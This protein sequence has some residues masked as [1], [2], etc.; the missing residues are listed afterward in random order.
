MRCLVLLFMGLL[1]WLA[2]GSFSYGQYSSDP[3]SSYIE[4]SSSDVYPIISTPDT[5]PYQSYSYTYSSEPISS[6]HVEQMIPYS[7]E[8][9]TQNALWVQDA[10]G[11]QTQYM[12]CSAFSQFKII[13]YSSGGS[14]IMTE[15]YPDGL[16]THNFYQF[17]PGYTEMVFAADQPGRHILSYELNGQISNAV[18]ID[19]VGQGQQEVYPSVVDMTQQSTPFQIDSIIRA[20]SWKD[21]VENHTTGMPP[22]LEGRDIEVMPG[23]SIQAAIDTASPGDTVWVETGTYYEN[24]NV[25]KQIA[26]LGWNGVQGDYSLGYAVVDANGR[27]SAITISA[28]GILIEGLEVRNSNDAGVL[29]LSDNNCVCDI[30]AYDNKYGI[31]LLDASYNMILDS[32]IENNHEYGVS[33]VRS[34][35]NKIEGNYAIQK[36]GNGIYIDSS[37]KNSIG[38][39]DIKENEDSGICLYL[40][41]DN[42]ITNNRISDNSYGALLLGSHNNILSYDALNDNYVY[43]AYDNGFNQWYDAYGE[44]YMGNYYGSG[45]N[46]PWEGC[47]YNYER[48]RGCPYMCDFSYAIPGGSNVDLYPV[49]KYCPVVASHG[50]HKRHK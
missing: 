9:G 14:A 33:L 46:L 29:V 48:D 17:P 32:K 8:S 41:N 23:E 35:Y 6:S 50:R 21:L 34:S 2:C 15:V 25:N 27:G 49:A 45:Y 12:Q 39:N 30:K 18:I 38:N 7:Q 31:S 26:L 22:L 43:N 36:N 28:D 24:V 37:N 19:V 40:S 42:S 44:G 13:A 3:F 16:Q 1:I 10:T 20:S 11:Q 4:I 5:D 47:T